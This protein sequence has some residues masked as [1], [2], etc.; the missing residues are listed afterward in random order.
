MGEYLAVRPR[1]R[2]TADARRNVRRGTHPRLPCGG[3][4]AGSSI[5]GGRGPRPTPRRT[6]PDLSRDRRAERV[7]S[8][9]R[10]REEPPREEPPRQLSLRRAP[11]RRL[12][13]RQDRLIYL[14]I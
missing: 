3:T 2:G 10:R 4:A 9:A 7:A 12:P 14:S 11:R 5:A 8:E 13:I 1:S 6:A